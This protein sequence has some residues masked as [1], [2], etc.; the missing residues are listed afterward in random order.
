M[1]R[2]ART[3]P[4]SSP[5]S[6]LSLCFFFLCN[7]YLALS[8]RS[9]LPQNKQ[10]N[11]PW[12]ATLT[13]ALKRN[14][15]YVASWRY[16]IFIKMFM[17]WMG[18]ILSIKSLLKHLAMA[19][20]NVQHSYSLLKYIYVPILLVP[21]KIPRGPIKVGM[22]TI[23][24]KVCFYLMFS[25]EGSSFPVWTNTGSWIRELGPM[26]Q[27]KLPHAILKLVALLPSLKACQSA[28]DEK[29]LVQNAWGYFSTW[30][31]VLT[32]HSHALAFRMRNSLSSESKA[33]HQNAF[34]F[35]KS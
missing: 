27:L 20:Y 35:Q 8:L 19:V 1:Q 12:H 6:P 24:N 17:V 33:A 4:T 13:I 18:N 32:K 2:F 23:H 5:H 14:T 34:F 25:L 21:S 9:F 11:S 31:N 22:P 10:K 26:A 3:N 15:M 28:F 29:G 7:I 16:I 30:R